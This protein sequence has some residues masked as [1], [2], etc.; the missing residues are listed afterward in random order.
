LEKYLYA[1]KIED[2]AFFWGILLNPISEYFSDNDELLD[3]MNKIT[4]SQ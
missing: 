4:G 3:T 2:E 1:L